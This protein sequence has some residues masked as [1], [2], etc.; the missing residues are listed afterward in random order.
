MSFS[1]L[2]LEFSNSSSKNKKI[3]CRICEEDIYREHLEE[4]SQY[5]AIIRDPALLDLSFEEQINEII[6]SFQE[7]MDRR[8]SKVVYIEI[9]DV[10]L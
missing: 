3:T 10:Y 8:L 6:H 1:V 5:C 7:V 9:M 4:H 2:D